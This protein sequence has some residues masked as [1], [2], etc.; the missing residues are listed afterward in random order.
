MSESQVIDPA[1][2]GQARFQ[3]SKEL[4]RYMRRHYPIREQGLRCSHED[5]SACRW[6]AGTACT[7]GR[8]QLVETVART[9]G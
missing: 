3:I 1:I 7:G 6:I 8:R 2:Q 5:R 4:I 9:A